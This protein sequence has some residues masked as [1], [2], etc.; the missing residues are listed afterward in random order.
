ME[1]VQIRSVDIDR[2][3]A[4]VLPPTWTAS[5]KGIVRRGMDVERVAKRICFKVGRRTERKC[6]LG[7]DA[8]VIFSILA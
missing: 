8:K 7:F 1:N 4:M 6:A 3:A 2:N 5:D